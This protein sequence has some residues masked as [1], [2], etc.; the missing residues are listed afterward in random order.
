MISEWVY[1]AD[2]WVSFW[3][4][5]IP[6]LVFSWVGYRV[7]AR[8]KNVDREGRSYLSEYIPATVLGALSLILG[9]TFSMALTRFEKRRQLTIEEAVAIGTARL[10]VDTI[11]DRA[12]VGVPDEMKRY[13]DARIAYYAAADSVE[14]AQA[15][16]RTNDSK[17]RIWDSV[18]EAGRRKG[19][20]MES[21]L[22]SSLTEM[23]DLAEERNIYL[24][25]T[26]PP[27]IYATILFVACL[28][29]AGFNLIRGEKRERG[30]WQPGILVLSYAFLFSLILDIDRPTAGM[31]QISQDAM[32]ELRDHWRE[33]D[34]KLPLVRSEV[35]TKGI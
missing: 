34:R 29:L 26:L 25:K 4:A 3:V 32:I 20:V 11:N 22:M 30:M 16:R 1:R 17:Y 27:M 14:T 24:K 28:G 23:F 6:L 18:V 15:D 13:L 7:G 2:Q 19:G 35:K 31:I 10:R 8:V 5:F 12:I 21:V 9:F 33:W